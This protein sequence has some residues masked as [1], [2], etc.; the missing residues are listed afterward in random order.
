MLRV[1]SVGGI[2]MLLL[3]RQAAGQAAPT[4]SSPVGRAHHTLFYD[5]AGRRVLL[6]GGT[7][8]D[9]PRE[10]ALLNDLWS[11]DGVN[12]TPLPPSGERM[13]GFRA[14]ADAQQRLYS[15]GG[16]R[17]SSV[18]DLRVLENGQWRRLGA[19]PSLVTAEAG[20]VFDAARNRFVAFG[21][22]AEQV[23]SDVWEYD[24]ARW[25]RHPATPPPARGMHAMVYDARRKK[26]VVFG[27]MGART[28]GQSSSILGDTWE[29]DGTSWTR[30]QRAGPP[31]RLGAGATYDSKRGV[32][33]LFGGANDQ[34]TLNDLWSW[35]GSSWSK[36]AD[37]GP[38][39]RVMGFI[40]YD[41][42][43]DRTVLFGGR[44]G[45]PRNTA[46]GDTWEWDGAAWRKIGR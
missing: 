15:F 39:P 9:G 8:G 30:I 6:A 21:G 32:V 16:W 41:A 44:L 12:W 28:A 1:L 7:S 36:L 23:V 2:A 17:D 29:F 33:L 5:E 14:A 27:G 10:Y 4:G 25:T 45:S 22:L 26:I 20:F 35:D 24:G 46:L 13:S 34:G 38:E 18:G 37:G 19:H 42:Q 31:P 3:V 43:R 11:F 40:V